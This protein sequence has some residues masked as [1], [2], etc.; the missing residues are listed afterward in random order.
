MSDRD[1]DAWR[2]KFSRPIPPELL[3]LYAAWREENGFGVEETNPPS[4]FCRGWC[5]GFEERSRI[6]RL[7][8]GSA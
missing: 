2:A 1:L 6:E 8:Q 4:M 7:A 3:T 5:W